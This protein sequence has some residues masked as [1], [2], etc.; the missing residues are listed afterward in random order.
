MFGMNRKDSEGL[1]EDVAMLGT[2]QR[3]TDRHYGP[4]AEQLARDDKL[5]DLRSENLQLATKELR[6]NDALKATQKKYADTVYEFNDINAVA[7]AARAALDAMVVELATASGRD[8]KDVRQSAYAVMKTVYDQKIGEMLST[9]MLL[10]DPRE[11]PEVRKRPSRD[12]YFG[13]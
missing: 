11:N 7:K 1:L 3:D 10:E 5:R 8:V 9:S 6:T 2:M 13:S 4:T 12:W